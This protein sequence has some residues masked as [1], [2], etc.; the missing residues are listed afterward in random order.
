MGDAGFSPSTTVT[1]QLHG[2]GLK[3]QVGGLGSRLP[4]VS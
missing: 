2:F 3:V 1:Q 4:I